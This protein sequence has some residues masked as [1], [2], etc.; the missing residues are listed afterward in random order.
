MTIN[1]I[2]Q[3]NYVSASEKQLRQAVQQL[4]DAANKRV[5]RGLQQ[6]TMSPAI[7]TW[8]RQDMGMFTPKDK[9]LNQLRAEFKRIKSFMQDKTSTR[10]GQIQYQKEVTERIRKQTGIDMDREQAKS[11]FNTLNKVKEVLPLGIGKAYGVES[12]QVIK[13]AAEMFDEGKS[14][15]EIIDGIEDRINE[16]ALEH[17]FSFDRW[18]M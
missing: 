15:E 8:Q 3:M 10:R 5:R 16:I 12:D 13:W 17:E 11:F 18:G 14:A 1:E 4:A 7:A 9:N 2:L 6:D